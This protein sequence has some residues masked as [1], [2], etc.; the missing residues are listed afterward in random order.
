M[1]MDMLAF[2]KE[3]TAIPGVT[4]NERRVAEYIAEV[5]RPLCDEVR[6]DAMN[7]VLCHRMGTGPR[8]IVCAH[9][10]EIGMM[11]SRIE[12]DGSLRL[13]NVGGVDPRVLPGMRVRVYGKETLTGVVG[14]KAPHLLSAEEKDQNYTFDTLYVDMGMQ[15]DR[16]RELVR[17]GDT[18]C[19]E[20]RARELENGYL[21][22]KTCDDRAC[23]AIMLGACQLLQDMSCEAD[24]WFVATTQEEIGSYGATAAAFAVEPDYAVAFDVCHATTPGAPWN[25]TS[26]PDA[27]VVSKGPFLH[28]LLVEKLEETAREQNIP[29]NEHVGPRYTYT[30]ADSTATVRNGIPSVLLSLPLRYMHTNVETCDTKVLRDGAR[31]LAHY[32]RAFDAS[33]EGKLWI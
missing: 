24:V 13:K 22:V 6:I 8:V 12:E 9:L 31:L 10:D 1:M 21:S 28:P 16:V 33:W 26:P 27:L 14:A 32:L 4:G 11:V 18:V 2:L 19:F 5:F 29:L 23:V 7:N 20:H 3:V 25:R 15:P 30:D 17:P